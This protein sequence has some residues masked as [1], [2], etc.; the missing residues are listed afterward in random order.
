MKSLDSAE[1]GEVLKEPIRAKGNSVLLLR[2]GLSL[3]SDIIEYLKLWGILRINTESDES[4]E[5]EFD[6]LSIFEEAERDA[7]EATQRL[8]EEQ[9]RRA[10]R[11]PGMV[12][13]EEEAETRR[14]APEL[15]EAEA[16][17][18]PLVPPME[19]EAPREFDYYMQNDRSQPL[20]AHLMVLA[21]GDDEE[22]DADE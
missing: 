22:M 20:V 14:P 18:V 11:P 21:A 9:Q 5:D 7:L 19:F 17:E 16:R 2:E 10:M 3:T 1:P 6:E 13:E 4:E 12:I 15:A 8:E